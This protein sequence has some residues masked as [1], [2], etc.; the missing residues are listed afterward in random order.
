M[1]TYAESAPRRDGSGGGPPW[2]A[3]PLPS[4]KKSEDFPCLPGYWV[5]YDKDMMR[6]TLFLLGALLAAAVHAAS[7]KDASY[8]RST[9]VVVRAHPWLT[10]GLPRES[11]IGIR[12]WGVSGA[13]GGGLNTV[14]FRLRLKN[15]TRKQLGGIKLWR[16]DFKNNYGFYEPR[17]I[18]LDGAQGTLTETQTAEDTYT[19]TFKGDGNASEGTPDW[20]YPHVPGRLVESDYIWLTAEIDPAISRD[21]KI[22]ADVTDSSISIGGCAYQVDNN[23]KDG[24]VAPHRVYPYQYRVNAYLTAGS[25]NQAGLGS[26]LKDNTE[27]RLAG[28]TDVMVATAKVNYHSEDATFRMNLNQDNYGQGLRKLTDLRDGTNLSGVNTSLVKAPHV[29]VFLSVDKGPRMWRPSDTTTNKGESYETSTLGHAVGDKYRLAFVDHLVALAKEYKLN[30]VDIDWEYPN[31]NADG[32]MLNPRDKWGEYGKYGLFLRDL[33]EA[34]FNEGLEVAFCVNQSGWAMPTS[35]DFA[36]SADFVN[37]MA[38]GP[39]PTFLGND[40]MKQGLSVC[41]EWG[42]PNR[43]ILVGQSIYSSA[44]YHFGWS[45]LRG[46]IRRVHSD[47]LARLDCDTVWESWTH[48]NDK[49]QV[50]RTGDFINFTGPST[51]R[52]KCNRT[53]IEGYGGVMS[54]GYYTD[55]SWGDAD[56]L[57]LGRNQWQA[58]WPHDFWQAPEQDT[59]GCYLLDSEEDWFWFQENPG[60]DVRLTADITFTH[61]PLP[62]AS[63]SRTLDGNGHTLTLPKEVW[64]CTFGNTALFQTLT[65]TVKDLTVVLEGR[66]VTRADREADRNV[67]GGSVMPSGQFYS[68]TQTHAGTVT[69]EGLAAVLAASLNSPGRL[70]NVTIRIAEGAEVQG[71]KQAGG[72]VAN[73]WGNAEN[74]FAM[75]GVRADI[76]GTVRTET[77]NSGETTFDVSQVCAGGLVGWAGSP[78]ANGII[79]EDCAVMLRDTARIANDTGTGDA[80]GGVLGNSNN[81]NVHLRGV[82]VSWRD[83][84]RVVAKAPASGNT[85]TPSPWISCYGVTNAEPGT[86]TG[87]LRV[88]GQEEAAF[89]AQ[90][91][92]F[93]LMESLTHGVLTLPGYRLR[94]R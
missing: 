17:A 55:S 77:S 22:Y 86:H 49:G 85:R 24:T 67:M 73:V 61:D 76:A 63:F 59:D 18:R 2:P 75:K 68:A 14:T 27:A 23:L 16:M 37:S 47:Y 56:L 19:F 69:G 79:L 29:R 88:L 46:K 60:H 58:I 93:W 89:E 65:G 92:S 78:A 5:C 36:A 74:W 40:V 33:S 4:A 66:V 11:L 53:R 41:R 6:T 42:V 87:T 21:A 80:A 82:D 83:G 8:T 62:I 91:P 50:N 1:W 48:Y 15:C 25:L 72:V 32:E 51:Y 52:A 20:F 70:E 3:G 71:A 81:G 38:Y 35:G 94:L 57:S 84:A 7:S 90:W 39:W 9:A 45:E 64:L 13:W 26:V 30:G 34:F 10:R 31:L 12:F 43:R 54:W 28:L 44:H